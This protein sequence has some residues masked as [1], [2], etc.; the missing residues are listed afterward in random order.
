ML[1]IFLVQIILHEPVCFSTLSNQI[2]NDK[3]IQSTCEYSENDP[4]SNN[5]MDQEIQCDSTQSTFY[6]MH[7]LSAISMNSA[8]DYEH[9]NIVLDISETEGLIFTHKK[10][11]FDEFVTDTI[12]NGNVEIKNTSDHEN[13][14]QKSITERRDDTDL[15]QY[16]D[17][18]ICNISNSNLTDSNFIN[19]H[20]NNQSME[21]NS[22]ILFTNM[23]P[24][25]ISSTKKSVNF[26]NC[27]DFCQFPN[28]LAMNSIH[29]P[30]MQEIDTNQSQ[31]C[32]NAQNTSNFSNQFDFSTF[33]DI[34]QHQIPNSDI[35]IHHD[36]PDFHGQPQRQYLSQQ[37]SD[38]FQ[39]TEFHNL[40]TIQPNLNISNL[41]TN[42]NDSYDLQSNQ[43]PN[44]DH[45][46]NRLK[47]LEN[48]NSVSYYS[49]NS[50]TGQNNSQN[51][52]IT[53]DSSK[54]D[55]SQKYTGEEC[56][57]ANSSLTKHNFF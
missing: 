3:Y 9:N 16:F 23:V 5:F 43:P 13:I 52:H 6:L 29:T 47:I 4:I 41:R 54:T 51:N 55:Q 33:T 35:Q 24:N 11:N 49:I 34:Q 31:E 45:F 8:L 20:Q 46:V 7:E 44:V 42:Q 36:M 53:V 57:D 22:E 18:F 14:L 38:T 10:H 26:K 27:E 56:S 2:N 30:L 15:D 21:F 17:K 32:M 39:N 25:Q 48:D 28:I 50:I 40:Q 1:Q 12:S 19:S 37:N